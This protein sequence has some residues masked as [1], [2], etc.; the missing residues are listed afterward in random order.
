MPQNELW[1]TAKEELRKNITP[2]MFAAWFENMECV[3]QQDDEVVLK[4]NSD[5]AAMWISDNYLDLLKNHLS[6]A[7]GRN[8][9]V[10]LV[11]ADAGETANAP[12]PSQ[13]STIVPAVRKAKV[14]PPAI[15]AR[16]T[17]ENFVVGEGN[18]FAHTAAFAVAKA[19]GKAYN[20][21]LIYGASGTG[22]THLMHAIAHFIFQD[23]P[24]KRIVYIT[25]EHFVNEYLNDLANK[26]ILKFRQRYRNV[27]VL[28]IDDV[29]FFS[30]KESCQNEFFHT[31]NDLFMLQKQIVLSCDKPINEVPKLEQRLITR[32]E[33]GL[34]IDIQPPDYETRLNI[35]RKKAEGVGA[36]IDPSILDL[37]A[38][39]ITKNVRRLEG[40]LNKV[41]GYTKLV[42]NLD[43]EEAQKLLGPMFVQEDG[44]TQIGI[45][46]IQTKV[47]EMYHITVEDM[48]SRRRP[49]K[50]TV[51]RQI[52]MYLSRKLTTHSLE[53][54]GQ[55]FGGRDHGTVMYAQK[56]VEDA[57]ENDENLKRSV[58][59][60][61]KMLSF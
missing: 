43:L 46:V 5:F 45:D 50:I 31:F 25:S 38:H 4:T 7:A 12:T 39:R 36:V 33:W 1:N 34:S 16:N 30:G 49:A 18:Q 55:L 6:L 54:I 20:P 56:A 17:F 37:I 9:S 19:P 11:A 28:L 60:L 14:E 26:D 2:E 13:I 22:K 58:E 59:Y 10:K 42:G 23:D 27:D 32:F 41:V 29:Q 61:L 21:L 3:S 47:A 44:Q 48:K 51:P 35:L 52:A 15:D 53:E 24:S 57:M 40:A 8:V